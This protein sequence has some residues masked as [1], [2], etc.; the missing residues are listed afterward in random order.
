MPI[1]RRT[2]SNN[3]GRSGKFRFWPI[4]IFALYGF[5]YWQSNQQTVPVS[6]RTQIVDVSREQE[7]ALGLSS[8]E[9]I[10]DQSQVVESGPEVEIVRQIGRRIAAVSGET[11]FDWEFNV[12][13]SDQANAFALPGGKV[14][15][16]TG[17]LPVA[18][19]ENGI[20]VIMGHEIA[21]AI[22]RH[23]AERMTHDRLKQLGGM[24]LG[25]AVG[26][27]DIQAQRTV[28]GA[29]GL[30]SQFGIMLPF[31]RKHESEA[32]Y[33]GLI[34]VAK[35]CFDPREAPKVWQRM[36]EAASGAAPSEFMSTHPSADTRIDQFKQW[37]PEALEIFRKS[38]QSRN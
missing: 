21:H 38:C 19:N 2:G 25:M 33:I 22:A 8:Y 15:F 37:M 35:A 23:G 7:V 20:A 5:Y 17:I 4:I 10:L 30:G 32:D 1:F 36:K 3:F 31:S 12:I 11:D 16:Y 18:E 29:F 13:Q 34:Y 14:A 9:Q 27:M 28:M 26:E 24:A 6:G